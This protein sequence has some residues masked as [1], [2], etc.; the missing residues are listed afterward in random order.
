MMLGINRVGGGGKNKNRKDKI[1][2]KNEKLQEN[3]GKR[4]ERE[5]AAKTDAAQPSPME[6]NIH[7]SRRGRVPG[8]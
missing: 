4:I 7:P 5:K 6:D 3:R 1:R 2:E 8:M